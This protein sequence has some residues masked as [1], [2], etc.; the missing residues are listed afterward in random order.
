M[1]FCEQAWDLSSN[2]GNE[3][4]ESCDGEPL[5]LMKLSGTTS[6]ASVVCCLTEVVACRVPGPKTSGGRG[7][8]GRGKVESRRFCVSNR[9]GKVWVIE[10]SLRDLRCCNEVNFLDLHKQMRFKSDHKSMGAV[11]QEQLMQGGTG[12]GDA[13]SKYK[14]DGVATALTAP[15]AA[16]AAVRVESVFSVLS[17]CSASIVTSVNDISGIRAA[18]FIMTTNGILISVDVEVCETCSI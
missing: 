17:M 14:L 1:I 15:S 9:E 7:V 2:A 6:T 16:T 13:S 11:G 18:V 8:G 5:F 12:S 10:W 4:S 3:S